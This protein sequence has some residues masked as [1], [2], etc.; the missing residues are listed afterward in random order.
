MIDT[1]QKIRVYENKKQLYVNVFSKNCL[2]FLKSMWGEKDGVFYTP[3]AKFH[4]VIIDGINK[5]KKLITVVQVAREMGKTKLLSFGYIIWAVAFKRYGYIL[6]ISF[7]LEGKG[8]QIMRDLQR[9]F[10]SPKFV[11]F[12]GDWR[13][14]FWGKHKIHL[15]STAWKIDCVIEVKGGN[16]SIFG[17]SE[18]KNRPDLIILDD[19]ENMDTVKNAEI[20]AGMIERFLTEIIPA[21]EAKDSF[22]RQAKIIIIGS[23]LAASTFLTEISAWKSGVKVFKI[24][25]LVDEKI[26]PGMSEILGIPEGRS[27][28]EQR[29]TTKELEAKRE[30]FIMANGYQSW[31]SQYMM[32]PVTGIPMQF[33]P[34]KLKEVEFKTIQPLI[35]K[36]KVIHIVDMAYTQKRQ[37][38]YVGIDTALHLPGSR[39]I[40]LESQQVKVPP[41]ELF[42]ILYNLK[43]KYKMAAENQMFCETKQYQLVKHYFWEVEIRTGRHLEIGV[44]SDKN[45]NPNDRI[46]TMIPFYEVGLLEFVIGQNRTLL[47]QMGAWKGSTVGH[48]DVIAAAAY[49]TRFVELSEDIEVQGDAKEAEI[50]DEFREMSVESV[51][52]Y[53]AKALIKEYLKD[54][55]EKQEAEDDRDD[56]I[57]DGH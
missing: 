51:D 36:G 6:H 11:R 34:S 10:M 31:L 7:S 22:G 54:S 33:V 5:S 37:N 49:Q 19:I 56:F 20:V 47:L 39:I 30:L 25:A 16:Q 26:W 9:G 38:D 21:A 45:I 48:D 15:H 50:S 55:E 52:R 35:A 12:F 2:L 29:W 57:F 23:P 1:P 24:P 17:A 14:K 3:F 28:W 4:K 40:H 42:D 44:I 13:G 27:V 41:N 43:E 8:E 32:D 53:D 46:G 18:W